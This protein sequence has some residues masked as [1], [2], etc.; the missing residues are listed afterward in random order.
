MFW[1]C[2]RNCYLPT[3]TSSTKLTNFEINLS[4]NDLAIIKSKDA[5]RSPW[6]LGRMLNVYPGSDGVFCSVKIKTPNGELICPTHSVCVFEKFATII[7][8]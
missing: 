2:W 4:K 1:N 7:T 8:R 5:P 6:P 3:L